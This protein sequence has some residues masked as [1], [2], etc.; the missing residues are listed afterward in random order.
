VSQAD[1]L[2]AL[3]EQIAKLEN[4]LSAG[5]TAY[6]RAG[7]DPDAMAAA[8]RELQ[9]ELALLRLRADDIGR[10]QS[11][12]AAQAGPWTGSPGWPSVRPRGWRR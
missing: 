1:E 9:D 11:S 6:L 4:Q 2:A 10:Y 3:R 8:T 12:T 7:I 5:V